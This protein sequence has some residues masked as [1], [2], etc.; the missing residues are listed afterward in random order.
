M[1]FLIRNDKRL[2][3]DDKLL[4]FNYSIIYLTLN[5]VKEILLFIYG[6]NNLRRDMEK[7]ITQSN[8]VLNYV[9]I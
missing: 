4:N 8:Y 6:I 3:E 9:N 1:K 5:R 7:E 2:S